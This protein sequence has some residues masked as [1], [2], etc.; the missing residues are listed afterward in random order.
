MKM[1]NMFGSKALISIIWITIVGLAVMVSSVTAQITT[2]TI[3]GTVSD[4]NG[5]PV[6]AATVTAKNVDTGLTRTVTSGEDG[7]FRLDFLPVGNFVGDKYLYSPSPLRASIITFFS[8]LGGVHID[9]E[10]GHV[11]ERLLSES[12]RDYA[13][14]VSHLAR[15][16]LMVR[17]K[18][19][20]SQPS[21]SSLSA[22][23]RAARAIATAARITD[24]SGTGLLMAL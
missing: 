17:E 1:R 9:T 14:S 3:I 15:L 2:A 19:Y 18:L 21:P 10:N 24:K 6:P 12:E 8:R 22:R 11:G 5:A 20:F 13:A 23:S 16:Q 4:P 7:S